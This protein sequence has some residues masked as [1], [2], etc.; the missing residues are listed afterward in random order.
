MTY[1][2]Q[3]C[4]AFSL[5][6]VTL[7]LGI[8]GVCMMAIFGLLPISVKANLDSSSETGAI[9]VL[10]AVAADIRAT[11]ISSTTSPQYNVVFGSS[12]TLYFDATGTPSA[13]LNV[14]SRYQLN[15]SFPTSPAGIAYA[16]VD[17]RWPAAASSTTASGR[18]ETFVAVNR[19]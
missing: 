6:E 12:T 7:A 15:A 3:R 2:A 9:G 18:V 8:A 17:I 1:S 5:V 4:S 13:A 14:H 11:P 19:N 10:S 16:H